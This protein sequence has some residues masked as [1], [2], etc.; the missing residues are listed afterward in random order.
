MALLVDTPSPPLCLVRKLHAIFQVGLAVDCAVGQMVLGA[1]LSTRARALI[2]VAQAV[3][4]IGTLVRSRY[5]RE[6]RHLIPTH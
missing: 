4:V 5:N 1:M 2:P 6:A 3:K